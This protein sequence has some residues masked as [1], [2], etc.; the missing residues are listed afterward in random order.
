MSTIS[1][2]TTT[3]TA[4]KVTA[5]TT[6]TLVLQTGSTPTTA[7][8]I[9]TSQRVGIG[10][11][12][13]TAT[14]S[15]SQATAR[16]IAVSTGDNASFFQAAS[17][18]GAGNIFY[19]GIDNSTGSSFGATPYAGVMWHSGSYPLLFANN[20]T[21]RGRFDTSGRFLVGL[22]TAVQSWGSGAS[23]QIQIAASGANYPGLSAYAYSAGSTAG[24]M[25]ILGHSRNTTVGSITQTQ[26]GDSLGYIIFEG[27]HSGNALVGGAYI[28]STQ[29]GSA[30]AS[31]IPAALQFFT[32]DA[33]SGNAERAR[34]DSSGNLAVGT[35][36]AG[37]R[38]LYVQGNTAATG[39]YIT[40]LDNASGT[41]ANTFGLQINYSQSAPNGGSNQFFDCMDTGGL[42]ARFK[43]NGGLD[44]YSANNSNLSDRREKT[45]FAPAGEYLSKI[46][47]IPVQTFNYIDQN[48]EEDGGLTLGV[49]AQDVQAVAPEL[50][51]ETNWA[52]KDEEPKMRLSIYQ[53]DLQYALMKCIQEQQAIIETLTN[54]ITALEAK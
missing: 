26:S 7:V 43:S 30:G 28:S 49:V 47:A 18:N 51:T 33:V 8:T 36:N 25:L 41:A 29:T 24:G 3:T 11:S 53:T 13:P 6:G 48:M 27:A 21:E 40:T 17:N 45:N 38:R 16:I 52:A 14:L 12:T 46:C 20:N 34:I 50:V 31:Y 54:R 42:R 15:L 1:A 22:N 32:S 10:T 35:T 37:N 5:D 19:S 39:T 9:D 4:Y 23:Q 44:N 2:S